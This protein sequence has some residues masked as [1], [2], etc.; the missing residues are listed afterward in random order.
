MRKRGK[1]MLLWCVGKNLAVQRRE[2]LLVYCCEQKK[3]SFCQ[4]CFSYL[5]S[6]LPDWQ[7][8]E[9]PSHLRGRG[10]PGAAVEA[11][12]GARWNAGGTVVY[13]RGPVMENGEK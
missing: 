6:P 2:L 1:D 11:D 5:P 13:G 8:V 10:P 7:P 4:K 9:V 3:A 12:R